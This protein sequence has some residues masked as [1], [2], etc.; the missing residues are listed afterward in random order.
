MRT[1]STISRT[2]ALGLTL[3]LG[4]S[5][6][7]S[8]DPEP[9][10]EPTQEEAAPT[11]DDGLEGTLTANGWACEYF[12]PAAADH[13]AGGTATTPRGIVTQ[14]DEEG[15]VCEVVSGGPGEQEPIARL[16]IIL[17]PE[18]REEYRTLAEGAEGVEPGPDY[19]GK[20]YIA[21][22]LVVGLTSC[23]RP[24]ATQRSDQ[25]EHTLVGEA[26]NVTDEQAT[27]DLRSALTLAAQG[28][29]KG[30]GCSPAQV[31]RDLAETT[32]AP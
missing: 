19:L 20:S 14:D 5:A 7:T 25:I 2:A 29:D 27:D 12:S 11:T 22:G 18:A 16:S 30:M 23:T 26:L 28:L 10:A 32:S 31:V 6:C 15:W 8:E 24:G 1:R 4:L 13:A 9:T 3:A 17:G 21:P